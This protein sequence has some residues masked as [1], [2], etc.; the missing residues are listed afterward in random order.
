M[1][2]TREIM[3]ESKG[4]APTKKQASWDRVGE[5]RQLDNLPDHTN[6]RQRCLG[7]SYLQSVTGDCPAPEQ[8]TAQ[9]GVATIQRK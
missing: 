8:V 9:N 7:N 3:R 6:F 4:F 1:F 2:T 5:T